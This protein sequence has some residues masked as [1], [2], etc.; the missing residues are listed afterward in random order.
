MGSIRTS[1][2]LALAGA[3]MLVALPAGAHPTDIHTSDGVVDSAVE[4]A[5]QHGS[6]DGH[7][8]AGSENV[9][10]IGKLDVNPP[11]GGIAD[12]A[13]KGD[14]AYLNAW[15]PYCPNAGVIVADISDPANPRR[16][17]F[18]RANKNSYPG[19]GAQVIHVDTKFFDGD[20]LFTN[21]E[22]C[23]SAKPFDGGAN[24]WNVTDPT[25]PIV[26]ARGV[27][28][29][30]RLDP[31]VQQPG[32]SA[33]SSHSVFAW[34]AGAKAYMVLVDNVETSDVDII[35]VTQPWAPKM[36][37][38]YNLSEEFPQIIQPDLGTGESFFH[39]VVVKNINGR[40]IM[41]A[42][43]WD[44]GYVLLDVTDPTAATY[45]ADSDFP[46][47]DREALESGLTVKPEGN[48][49]EAEF[50]MNN[51]YIVAAD[52]DFNP[53]SLVATN[54]TDGEE[55]DAIMGTDTPAIEPG[56]SLTGDTVFVGLACPGD[57]VPPAP[58]TTSGTQI[59][60]VERGVCFF[61]EKVAAVEAA[62]G[63]EGII[64]FNREGA[65]G[66]SDLLIMDVQG[67]IPSMF[68]GRDTGWDLLNIP[69]YDDAACR[70]STQPTPSSVTVGTVG[71]AV[72]VSSIFDGWGYVHLYA[73]GTGKLNELD[74]Y[75]VPEAHDPAYA[76]GFGDLSVHE[77]AMSHERNELAYFS[78]YSAGFRVA[79]IE[80]GQ[81]VEQG[82]FIDEGG[83]NFWGVEV[84]NK[85]GKEY[86]LGS[87]RD[88]GL[89]I[90][91]Y[92]GP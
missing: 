64:V 84:W 86:V 26:V 15:Q 5:H 66:C 62:G 25:H 29:W 9:S 75:A 43:Y 48:A 68:V 50:S 90:F 38:E 51:D 36:I 40:W 91:E 18:M 2:A 61:T 77:V 88:S 6:N 20:L 92:T 19:E 53:Y 21:N 13:V 10:V 79:T 30:N 58:S 1:Y 28:D 24:I 65:D 81:L 85:D 71:D 59:A 78:Y 12:V 42:S 73:N 82:H 16:V 57:T 11:E 76:E 56:S 54:T 69:G 27:G 63:Y 17:G 35:D 22:P 34:D 67:S 23:N 72:D 55:F 70:V 7:L 8:P 87:D 4:A 60:L 89:Y 32:T 83:N 44:G 80:S 45:V 39:D 46:N 47:P 52:E 37:A 74:T 41:L 49:H 3:L 14:Y 33:N 31:R